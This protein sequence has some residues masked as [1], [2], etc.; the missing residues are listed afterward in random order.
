MQPK[1]PRGSP[2]TDVA[3]RR[4]RWALT[5]L[6][7]RAVKLDSDME[8]MLDRHGEASQRYRIHL[9]DHALRQARRDGI[10]PYD[11]FGCLW[12]GT[13][14]PIGNNI[15]WL[16]RQ[17]FVTSNRTATES[18]ITTAVVESCHRSTP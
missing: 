4:Q 10:G 11:I 9:T 18:G 7:E 1:T 2:V 12:L 8:F 17:I 14:R 13:R 3:R 5:S 16:H 15:S 6:A